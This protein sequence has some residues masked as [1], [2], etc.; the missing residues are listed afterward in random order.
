MKRTRWAAAAWLA[1]IWDARALIELIATHFSVEGGSGK[2]DRSKGDEMSNRLAICPEGAAQRHASHSFR[3][4]I[5]DGNFYRRV[6]L[7]HGLGKDVHCDP[8]HVNRNIHSG[9]C[10]HQPCRNCFWTSGHVRAA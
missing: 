1:G 6:V 8:G 2:D 10:N 9:S 3:P 7:S 4:P 5:R